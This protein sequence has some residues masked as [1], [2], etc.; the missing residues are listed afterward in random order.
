MS[1]ITCKI[2]HFIENM[3]GFICHKHSSLTAIIGKY[4]KQSLVGS[5]LGV[6]FIN[7]LRACFLYKILAPKITKLYFGFETFWRQNT[8]TKC[9]HK[10]LMKL[11]AVVNFKFPQK[12]LCT[13]FIQRCFSLALWF[14]S[15]RIL[16]KKARKML[17]KSTIGQIFFLFRKF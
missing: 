16:A 13:F 9:E 15:K 2:G 11:T 17:M 5:T 8:G 14:F 1:T 6:N 10:M 4:V 7:I 3:T 12:I